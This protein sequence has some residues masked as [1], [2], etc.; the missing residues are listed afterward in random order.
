MICKEK[1]EKEEECKLDS[2][3]ERIG[4]LEI[5]EGE[6]NHSIAFQFLS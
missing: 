5:Q 2:E 6:T 1:E 4:E 3:K